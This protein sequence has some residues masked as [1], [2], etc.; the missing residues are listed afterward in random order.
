MQRFSFITGLALILLTFSVSIAY[1][2]SVPFAAWLEA[3]NAEALSEGIPQETLDVALFNI[4]PN[5]Q[6]VTLDRKQPEGKLTWLQYESRIVA[7][8]RIG[9]GQAKFREH[10]ALLKQVSEM[11]GVQP[12]IIVALWG[13]ETNY[14]SYTGNYSVFESLATLAYDGRRADLFRKELKAALKIAA[15]GKAD[16]NEMIGS[17]AGA[18]GQTQF[19]PSSYLKYAVD[20]N[21]NDHPDIWH[22]Q[23]DVFA[24]IANYLKTEGWNGAL[25]WGFRVE[26]PQGFN[27]EWADLYKARPVSEWKSLGVVP[28]GNAAWP[29]DETPIYVMYPGSNSEAAYAVTQNYHVLLHWNR[30]RYFATSVGLLSDKI[31]Q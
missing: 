17:W 8:P 7:Q 24:S 31:A 25:P 14:G 4:A 1:A 22:T 23:E 20:W 3:F 11:Y 21:G 13:T 18:M 16:P 9:Q 12:Q 26:L 6:L 5:P 19:M 15:D 28:V 27:P 10:Q 30:S 2:N 29:A